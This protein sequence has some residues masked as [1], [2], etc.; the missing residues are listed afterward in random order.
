MDIAVNKFF[1]LYQKPTSR[2]F[3]DLYLILKTKKVVWANLSSL[4]RVKFDTNIDSLQLGSQLT[5]AKT[6]SDLPRLLNELPEALWRN[7][8]IKKALELKKDVIK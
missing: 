3:I 6:I 2:H 7:F 1:A 8:F 4:A 5:T